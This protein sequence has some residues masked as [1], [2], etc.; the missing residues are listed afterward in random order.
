MAELEDIYLPY[1]PKRRTRATIAREKG[2]EP[3]ALIIMEQKENDPAHKAEEFLN[4]DVK[5]VEDAIAGAS[6]IIAEWISEDEKARKQ[7]RYLFEKEAVIYFKS[8]KRKR[9]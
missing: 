2:L 3:L 1:R 8:C 7:L 5:T 9:S 6:D 4:D